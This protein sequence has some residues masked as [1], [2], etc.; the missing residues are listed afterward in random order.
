MNGCKKLV[1]VPELPARIMKLKMKDCISLK[2]STAISKMDRLYFMTEVNLLN[3]YQLA[4][5]KHIQT[6]LTSWMQV[7]FGP[8][9]YFFD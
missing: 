9:V 2:T 4:D 1:Q 8:F 6:L 7:S 5:D 3:C